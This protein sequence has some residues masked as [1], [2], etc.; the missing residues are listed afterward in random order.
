MEEII[1]GVVGLVLV[2]QNKCSWEEAI[3]VSLGCGFVVAVLLMIS[4]FIPGQGENL[5]LFMRLMLFGYVPVRAVSWLSGQRT[6]KAG[7]RPSLHYPLTQN[8]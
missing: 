8:A 6:A 3:G 1:L 4:H 5:A 2:R 7:A